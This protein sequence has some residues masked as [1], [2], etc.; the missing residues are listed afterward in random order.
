MNWAVVTWLYTYVTMHQAVEI[1]VLRFIHSIIC[2]LYLLKG[3]PGG[4][5]V[6]NLPAMQKTQVLSPGWEDPLQEEVAPTTVFL[7]G[8]SHGQR[9]VVGYSPWG[10]KRVR[11]NLETKTTTAMYLLKEKKIFENRHKHFGVC[12]TFPSAFPNKEVGMQA[13]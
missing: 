3:F 7:A 4:S 13:K 6:K 9:T 2:R 10:H 5:G 12:I 8:K 11:H 1:R